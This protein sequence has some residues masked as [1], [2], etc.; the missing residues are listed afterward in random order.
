[1]KER[2]GLLY[3]F[4]QDED[5]VKG[6]WRRTT[7]EE[8]RKDEPEWE[9][10]LD[11]D[12]LAKEEDKSWVFGGSQFLDYGPGPDEKRKDRVMISLSVGGSDAT[13]VREARRR[14]T[15]PSLASA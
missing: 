7:W 12:A 10:V 3:N 8:Y 13:E 9:L 15:A 5:H 4:W 6:I 14:P 1:M 2:G 11:I